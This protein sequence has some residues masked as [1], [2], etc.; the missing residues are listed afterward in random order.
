LLARRTI[1]QEAGSKPL[2]HLAHAMPDVA[3]DRMTI[4]VRV[5]C[6]TKL[7]NLLICKEKFFSTLLPDPGCGAKY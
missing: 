7:A 2:T 3:F 6:F 4:N 5:G 1:E